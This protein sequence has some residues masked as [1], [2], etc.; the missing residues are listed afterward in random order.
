MGGET[1][2]CVF[3][4]CF[5]VNMSFLNAKNQIFD[6]DLVYNC[7]EFSTTLLIIRCKLEHLSTNDVTKRAIFG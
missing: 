4:C 1:L 7:S 6:F 2:K 5:I 3:I